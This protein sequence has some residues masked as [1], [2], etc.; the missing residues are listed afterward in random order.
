MW[1]RL[2]LV[3]RLDLRLILLVTRQLSKL[4][5]FGYMKFTQIEPVRLP[6]WYSLKVETEIAKNFGHA[7][8]TALVNRLEGRNGDL[9][10]HWR[11]ALRL[12]GNSI[13]ASRLD[14]TQ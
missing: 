14:L 10:M 9:V 12:F 1:S 2:G 7:P 4:C 3:R 6:I 5:F 11:L 13:V 8:Q